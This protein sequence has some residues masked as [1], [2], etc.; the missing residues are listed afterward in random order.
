MSIVIFWILKQAEE[1]TTISA[2][3]V[4]EHA[5]RA[6]KHCLSIVTAIFQKDLRRECKRFVIL[7]AEEKKQR[8]EYQRKYRKRN[9]LQIA[10][11]NK[12]YWS[13]KVR[14]LKAVEQLKAKGAKINE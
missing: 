3:N 5:N 9:P 2:G 4:N 6:L 10:E 1:N 11:A 13:R 14:E 7:T 8:A 12:R